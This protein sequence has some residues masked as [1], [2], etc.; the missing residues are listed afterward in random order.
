M[1]NPMPHESDGSQNP[2]PAPQPSPEEQLG[3]MVNAAVSAHI[4]R[5]T[6]KQLPAILES[7]LKPITEKLAAP[8]P[9][10]DD[11][12][13]KRKSKQDPETLALAK[14]LED[15]KKELADRDQKVAAAEKRAREERAFG[16]LRTSLEGKVRP[17]LLDFVAKHLVAVENRL[18]F[19]ENGTPLFKSQR[20]P[21]AGA[22]PEEINLPLRAGIDEFLK[23]DSAKPF[24]PAPSSASASPL[25]KRPSMQQSSGFDFSRPANSD[26]EKAARSLE[27]ERL[28]KERLGNQ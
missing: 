17:E 23:S 27:R 15:L 16:D 20:V 25:P 7:A 18:V 3:N 6:E 5:F 24:L 26:A 12:G 2:S 10:A 1:E 4:K 14:Q 9:P 21:Y 22:E 13:G 28:A 8:P 11:E 19:D